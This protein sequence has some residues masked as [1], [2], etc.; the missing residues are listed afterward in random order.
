M[1]GI[2]YAITEGASLESKNVRLPTAREFLEDLDRI[3]S[4]IHHGNWF[5]EHEHSGIRYLQYCPSS[6][7]SNFA[8]M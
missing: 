4:I 1:Q 3:T 2:Y 7:F 6:A 5:I 8:L